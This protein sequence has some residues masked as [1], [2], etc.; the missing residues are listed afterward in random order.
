[1]MAP[2]VVLGIPVSKSEVDTYR[3]IQSQTWSK[4]IHTIFTPTRGGAAH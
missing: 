3:Q 1:M 4:N 2:T